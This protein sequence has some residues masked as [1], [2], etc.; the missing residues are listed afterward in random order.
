MRVHTRRQLVAREVMEPLDT[1]SSIMKKHGKG[2][3]MHHFV[4]E[5]NEVIALQLMALLDDMS[6]ARSDV[7]CPVFETLAPED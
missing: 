5:R 1:M 3:S 4:T 2:N 6:V 7:W